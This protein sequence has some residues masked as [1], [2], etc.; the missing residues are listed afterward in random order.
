MDLKFEWDEE[1]EKVNLKNRAFL[2]KQRQR[3]S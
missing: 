3:F 2:L 1:K